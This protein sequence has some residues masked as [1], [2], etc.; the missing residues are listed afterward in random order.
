MCIESVCLCARCPGPGKYGCG[1]RVAALMRSQVC[2]RRGADGAGCVERVVA[3]DV[4]LVD[5]TTKQCDRCSMA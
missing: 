4:Y 1:V 2:Q 5:G 3:R